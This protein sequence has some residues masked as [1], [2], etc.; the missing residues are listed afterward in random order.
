MGGEHSTNTTRFRRR[1]SR[2]NIAD[3]YVSRTRM[4]AHVKTY[5]KLIVVQDDKAHFRDS[6]N[7]TT[8]IRLK[9]LNK[10]KSAFRHALNVARYRFYNQ[11]T[12][13]NINV[14]SKKYKR[15]PKVP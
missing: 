11:S 7:T 10:T 3:V 5:L 15:V 6:H 12:R 9:Q 8:S 2:T 13:C 4:D 14:I 1:L